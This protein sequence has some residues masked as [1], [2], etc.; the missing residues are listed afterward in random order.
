MFTYRTSEN[1]GISESLEVVSEREGEE[2]KHHREKG[3]VRM[4]Q[5]GERYRGGGWWSYNTKL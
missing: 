4:Y 2:S 3:S 5:H 1:L